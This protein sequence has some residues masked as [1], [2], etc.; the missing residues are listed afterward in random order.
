[1]S[2][3]FII[4]LFIQDGSEVHDYWL[5]DGIYG[6]LNCIQRDG[7]TVAPETLRSPL[8]PPV[9]AAEDMQL[10]P[11][12]LFGPTCDGMDTIVRDDLCSLPALRLGD[13]VIFRHMGEFIKA[14]TDKFVNSAYQ[15]K[16]HSG[17]EYDW[18]HCHIIIFSKNT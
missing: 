12:T 5:T 11:T 14:H 3:P 10:Y 1:M 17:E 16:G 13:W 9:S 7:A 4:N 6:S 8:L 18:I 2:I 15:Q